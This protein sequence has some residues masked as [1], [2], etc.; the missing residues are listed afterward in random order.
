[1]TLLA[2]HPNE[3]LASSIIASSINI[4]PVLVRKELKALKNYGL[5][6]SKEGKNGGIKLMKPAK[7]IYISDVFLS[8][9]GSEHVLSLSSNLPNAACKIGEQINDKLLSMF[10]DIDDAIVNRLKNQTLEA[11]KNQ[12]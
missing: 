11:F 1:M 8:A 10:V 2:Y 5:I 12:F 4:N 7:D 9:K 3:W 6:E